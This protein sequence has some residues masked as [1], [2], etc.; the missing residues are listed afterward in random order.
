[1][2][3]RDLCMALPLRALPK[4][5]PTYGVTYYSDPEAAGNGPEGRISPVRAIWEIQRRL[6]A[7]ALFTVDSGEHFFFAT[8]Y[9]RIARP[10]AFV[11]MTGLGSMASSISAMGAKLARPDRCVAA[12]CGDGGFRMMAT[13]LA[14]AARH[15]LEILVFVFN[16]MRLGMVEMGHQRIFGRSPGYDTGPLDIPAIARAVG[17]RSASVSRAGEILSLDIDALVDRGPAVVEVR[18]DRRVEMPK[19]RRFE[20]LGNVA[21]QS[22]SAA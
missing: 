8:H 14:T 19:N 2:F 5:P 18:I 11:V 15:R 13:E 10:D 16:D 20:T 1:V 22:R 3:L 21:N 17:A 6:P 4:T 9:L 7:D 12:I